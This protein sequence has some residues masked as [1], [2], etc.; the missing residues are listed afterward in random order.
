MKAAVLTAY[1]DV[2]VLEVRDV[3]EPGPSKGK[4][5]IKLTGASINR[6]DV[7]VRAG[8]VK[9]WFPVKFPYVLGFDG[10]G[11]VSDV[12]PDTAGFKVG[13]RVFGLIQHSHAQTAVAAVTDLAAVPAGLSL[14]DAASL[15]VVGLT[16]VQLVEEAI[17]PKRGDTIL[18]T[19]ALGSVGRAALYAAKSLGARVLV[20]V[21]RTQTAA[22]EK[23]GAERV[24]ALDDADGLARLGPLDAVA[25]TVGGGPVAGLVP[26]VKFGGTWASVVDEPPGAKE[27]GIKV[28]VIQTHP[29]AARL[30]A[31]AVALAAG[32]LVIPIVARFSLDQI[33]EAHRTVQQGAAGKVLVLLS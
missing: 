4:V 14:A 21:R 6:F 33:R 23:L 30:K 11:E 28:S 17:A 7:M 5:R 20:G 2:E 19:G 25:D 29:D 16:G 22:A 3:P 24:V 32:E 13:D 15:P 12:G 26:H 31:L 10:S 18:I 9:D 27:R 1:G 8:L